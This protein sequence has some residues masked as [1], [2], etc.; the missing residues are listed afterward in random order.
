MNSLVITF[1]VYF[2]GPF[3]DIK[4]STTG[5]YQY[6]IFIKFFIIERWRDGMMGYYPFQKVYTKQDFAFSNFILLKFN[7]IKF[8]SI[9]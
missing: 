9:V 3:L 1:G 7:V 4:I 5:L 2:K 8:A 6:L